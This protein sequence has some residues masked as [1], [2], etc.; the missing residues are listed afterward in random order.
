MFAEK[1]K[2]I[3]QFFSLPRWGKGDHEVVNEAFY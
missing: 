3:D 2:D 1:L